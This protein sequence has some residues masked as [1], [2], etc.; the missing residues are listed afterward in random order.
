MAGHKFGDDYKKDMAQ[1][2]KEI[3][4]IDEGYTRERTRIDCA[5]KAERAKKETKTQKLER[6]KRERR[7]RLKAEKEKVPTAYER[8]MEKLKKGPRKGSK[9]YEQQHKKS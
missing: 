7:E 4:R 1:L 5:K 6:F 8:R 3:Q 2:K 9:L